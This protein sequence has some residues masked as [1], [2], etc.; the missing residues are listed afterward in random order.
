MTKEQII[1][2]RNLNVSDL[3]KAGFT[4]DELFENGEIEEA[5]YAPSDSYEFYDGKCFYNASGQRLRN[6]AEYDTRSEGYT[7]FGD[8]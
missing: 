8:E 2:A 7:P 3:I 5:Y 6:P 1:T 4:L